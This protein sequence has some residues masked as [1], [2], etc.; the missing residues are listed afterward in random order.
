MA[1]K[2]Y[3][4]LILFIFLAFG[5]QAG[6]F[7]TP[8]IDES[9]KKECIKGAVRS[10]LIRR[11]MKIE[12]L[13]VNLPVWGNWFEFRGFDPLMNLQVGRILGDVQVD[14]ES[15]TT[16]CDVLSF[17]FGVKSEGSFA[18]TGPGGIH[19]YRCSSRDSTL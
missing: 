10:E 11:G 15:S 4:F 18:C 17:S 13:A 2:Q 5:S 16:K 8:G 14:L 12:N 19:P 6:A 3:N 9:S 7:E 1:N